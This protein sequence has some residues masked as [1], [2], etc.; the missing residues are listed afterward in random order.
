MLVQKQDPTTY[1]INKKLLYPT[2]LTVPRYEMGALRS[3]KRPVTPL[4]DLAPA[5]SPDSKGLTE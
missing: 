1:L 2:P 3:H 4:F 5:D